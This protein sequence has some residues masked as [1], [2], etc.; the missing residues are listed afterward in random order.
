MEANF[1]SILWN[2][3]IFSEDG[4]ELEIMGPGL[5]KAHMHIARLDLE[6]DFSRF[7]AQRLEEA[8][9]ASASPF[10]LASSHLWK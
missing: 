7:R 9:K 8:L 3:A 6:E 1:Y 4:L 2:D 10:Q 5:K